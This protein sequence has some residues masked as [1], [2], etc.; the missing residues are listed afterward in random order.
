MISSGAV[1]RHAAAPVRSLPSTLARTSHATSAVTAMTSAMACALAAMVCYGLGDLIYKQA[2]TAGAP[3]HR[4][5]MLQA[6]CFAPT[7][8]L[9]AWSTGTLI[10]S[11]PAG[12][13]A[14]AG[15]FIFIGF[16][17]FARSL[18]TGSVSINA[19]IFRMNFALTALLAICLLGEPLT[20]YKAGGLALAFFAV[21]LLLGGSGQAWSMRS[22]AT[23]QSLI[24]V[25]VATVAVGAANFFHKLGL[26]GGSLP[27]T[28][29]VA[30]AVVFCSLSTVFVALVDRRIEPAR[31]SWAWPALAAVVLLAAFLFLLQ[32]LVD[33]QASVFVPI[34]QMGFVVTAI[35]GI[36]ALGEALTLRKLTGLAVAF[37]ALAA[38]A[39]S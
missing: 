26:Q 6:W 34:A 23:R 14:L 1:N 12:W 3:A 39:A 37:A 18:A 4:F 21:W 32:S 31:Y 20:P 29:I 25:L 38:L 30:Q 35:V 13:G 15:L 8:T 10:L 22:R 11:P 33:G 19:P 28:L 7:A 24:Q 5:M 9:Y 2:A 36:V 17:N 27:A 16:Y